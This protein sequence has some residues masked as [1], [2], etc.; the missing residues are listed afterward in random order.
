MWARKVGQQMPEPGN[1]HP[2][3]GEACHH[4]DKL[5]V[6]QAEIWMFIQSCLVTGWRILFVF[7]VIATQYLFFRCCGSGQFILDPNP[8]FQKFQNLIRFHLFENII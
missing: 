4:Q 3:A 8:A 5:N 1:C 7:V 6:S 2:P